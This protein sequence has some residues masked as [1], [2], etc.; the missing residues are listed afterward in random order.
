MRRSPSHCLRPSPQTRGFLKQSAKACG[1]DQIRLNFP[2]RLSQA[3]WLDATRALAGLPAGLAQQ[4]LDELAAKMAMGGIRRTPLSYLRGLIA[5]A[6]SGTFEPTVDRSARSEERSASNKHSEAGR[7]PRAPVR[8]PGP[9]Y[10]DVDSNP[11]C[12]RTAEVQRRAMERRL[13]ENELE[14]SPTPSAE[15]APTQ[16]KAP[17][18]ESSLWRRPLFLHLRGVIR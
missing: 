18:D 11:L 10:A 3:E 13:H 14:I 12:Q 5:R 16:S 7:S 1:G 2:S 17:P 15:S 6:N 4:L 8:V 9:N